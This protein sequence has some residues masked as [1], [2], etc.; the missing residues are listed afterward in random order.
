MPKPTPLTLSERLAAAEAMNANLSARLTRL[1]SYLGRALGATHQNDSLGARRGLHYPAFSKE[2]MWRTVRYLLDGY[3]VNGKPVE[4]AAPSFPPIWDGKKLTRI[5]RL[6]A[7]VASVLELEGITEDT[8]WRFEHDLGLDSL[9]MA[10]LLTLIQEHYN[11]DLTDGALMA[12]EVA[13]NEKVTLQHIMDILDEQ[14]GPEFPDEKN[15]L[16]LTEDQFIV[17]YQPEKDVHGGYYHQRDL[18]DSDSAQLLDQATQELRCWT[19]VDNDNDE[20]TIVWGRRHVNR[21]YYIITEKPVEDETWELVIENDPADYPRILCDV[22]WDAPAGGEEDNLPKQV[23]VRLRDVG[24]DE[25]N[26]DN[27]DEINDYLSD[28]YGYCVLS[29]TYRDLAPGEEVEL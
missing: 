20:P 4:P 10:N 11:V 27:V 18:H 5:D 7:L 14:L 24:I 17:R 12:R 1:R 15:V 3:D 13:S 23:L 21:L 9:D 16:R 28:T 26:D 19:M 29:F 22:E 25:V 8:D 2:S 6:Q